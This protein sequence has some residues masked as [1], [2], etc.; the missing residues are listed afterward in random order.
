MEGFKTLNTEQEF[1]LQRQSFSEIAAGTFQELDHI[2][3]KQCQLRI[4][5]CPQF[6]QYATCS[7]AKL[8]GFRSTAR[9][10]SWTDSSRAQLFS[11]SASNFKNLWSSNWRIYASSSN[12]KWIEVHSDW[13]LVRNGENK[14]AT[15]RMK[16]SR[17]SMIFRSCILAA[18]RLYML[19]FFMDAVCSLFK[20]YLSKKWQKVTVIIDYRTRFIA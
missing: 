2:L 19:L 17:A 6:L 4:L 7:C 18:I 1:V 20:K 11:F 13:N 10:S 9:L 3:M 12:S 16:W 5:I 15:L 14:F 8:T